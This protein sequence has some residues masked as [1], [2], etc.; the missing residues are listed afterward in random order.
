MSPTLI[1]APAHSQKIRPLWSVFFLNSTQGME[2]DRIFDAGTTFLKEKGGELARL[3]P[4]VTPS[5]AR[6][7]EDLLS[8]KKE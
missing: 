1:P 2:S 7:Q 6:R 3:V 8:E 4:I 5:K